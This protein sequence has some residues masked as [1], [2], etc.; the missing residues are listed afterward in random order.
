MSTYRKLEEMLKNA[1]ELV[2][3]ANEQLQKATQV[4]PGITDKEYTQTQQLLEQMAI[5][6][7]K[8]LHSATPEQRDALTR[9]RQQVQDKQN[10]FILGFDT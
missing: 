9:A 7:D 10:D 5:D 3:Y 1:D 2:E 6:I 8:M 4:Q